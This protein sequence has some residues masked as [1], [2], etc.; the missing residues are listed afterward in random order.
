[1]TTD[2]ILIGLGLTVA[3]AVGA[4][5][6]AHTLRIPAIV[7]LLPVGFVAGALTDNVVPTNIVG[8]AFEPLVS[9][10]VAV[11][12]FD[13]GVGLDLR[14][15]AGSTRRVVTALIVLGIPIT[16]AIAALAGRLILGLSS[17]AALMLGAVL[18]VSGPTVVGPLLS[19]VR[20]SRRVQAVLEWESSVIDPIGAILGA[21]TFHALVAGDPQPFAYEVGQ[22]LT[23]VAVGLAG[24]AIGTAV[25]WLIFRRFSVS[26]ALGASGALATVVAV[27][28]ACDIVRED[29]G[30]FA[31]IV[32]GI[33]LANLAAF[34]VPVR[35]PFFETIIQLVI[36]LLFISISSTVT[37]ESVGD[38]LLPTMGLVA[39]LVLVGRPLVAL[40]ATARSDLSM[41]ERAF[42]GWMDPRGIV[43]AATA[44]AF[45]T[46]LVGIGVAGA[47]DILPV[48][49]VVIVGTVTLYGLT[50]VPV[51]RRLGVTRPAA[52]LPLIVGGSE[53]VV[54]LALALRSQ[55]LD[56]LMWAG[57]DGQRQRIQ[58]AGLRL[59]HGRLLADATGR[60]A[61]LEGITTVLLLTNEDDFNALA[62]VALEGTLDGG[63]YR[64]AAP[65]QDVGVVAPFTRGELLFGG[66]L[67]GVEIARRHRE[68]AEIIIRGSDQGL[69]AGAEPL[70]VVHRGGQLDP[71]T[72]ER[73]AEPQDGDTLVLLGPVPQRRADEPPAR[74]STTGDEAAAEE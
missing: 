29:T 72:A 9:L 44:S 42:V 8:P 40:A 4:Q 73:A 38:V 67:T 20:P 26:E 59:A 43:A 56:V 46:P 36:G 51:A 15:L 70:F 6:L 22:F 31:A 17:G 66:P 47:S 63:V 7:V 14:R 35:R 57:G 16:W 27:A 10:A 62:A 58:A 21:L 2:Q 1:M 25:L 45:S 69:P 55:G 34:D 5:I 68:G 37:P 18:V 65:S 32:M 19:F 50:A 3:L 71:V 52:S 24:G 60:G 12:L 11:I 28:A 39:V 49:F 30:L 74:A 13:S 23:S 53:W 54:D 33:A 48:T 64:V 41:G 61:E